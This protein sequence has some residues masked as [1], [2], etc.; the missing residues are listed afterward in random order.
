MY[1]LVREYFCQFLHESTEEGVCCVQ[2]WIYWSKCSIWLASFVTFSQELRLTVAPGL[3]VTWNEATDGWINQCGKEGLKDG[4][5]DL[6]D[7]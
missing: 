1:V 3:S 4:W 6:R 2:S 5:K 7:I